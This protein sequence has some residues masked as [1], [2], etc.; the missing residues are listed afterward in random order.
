MDA[1]LCPDLGI[2][3]GSFTGY[4]LHFDDLN[5][6]DIGTHNVTT[7][8]M[9]GLAQPFLDAVEKQG[10]EA[11]TKIQDIA[12]PHLMNGFDLMGVAQT[13]GG[14]TA[15]FVLPI[16]NRLLEENE[17]TVSGKP[18]CVILAPTRE[19][20]QQIGVAVRSFTKGQKIFHTVIFGGSPYKQQLQQLQRGVHIVVATPG[21]LMDHMERG[22]IKFDSVHTFV[23]DEADRMLDMGFIHDVKKVAAE[24]PDEKQT[25]MFSATMSKQVRAL[26]GGLLNKPKQVEVA[27]ENT[28]A[29]TI[30]HR[31]LHTKQKDKQRLL[32]HL[33]DDPTLKKVLIFTRT[34]AM[35]DRL[36]DNLKERGHKTDT[37]HGDR[38]QSARQ[39]VLRAFRNGNIELLVATDVAARG[40]DVADISHVINYDM[41]LE[42]DAY[43]HR[44]GRTGRAGQSGMALS[45]CTDGE[46]D[47]LQQIERTI[48]QRVD[49]DKDHPFHQ[50]PLPF[51]AGGEQKRRRFGGGGGGGNRKFGGGGP[52]KRKPE[53]GFKKKTEGGFKNKSDG[54]FKKRTDGGFKKHSPKKTHRKGGGPRRAA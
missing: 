20:A 51:K 4:Q 36:C 13:G 42:G 11:P 44:I 8:D 10:F 12:I 17:K 47:L 28:V 49:V 50:D 2:M 15:A 33:L 40:I 26:A 3:C 45:F 32:S 25:V 48:K 38:Q 5:A 37:I 52:N 29:E 30:D 9:L 35:A 31:V 19:L 34:K 27:R 16:L 22:S 53:G 24:M 7:F 39:R 14:K 23:L 1:F 43:V 46:S 41:P 21:R 6:D 18:R 54:G